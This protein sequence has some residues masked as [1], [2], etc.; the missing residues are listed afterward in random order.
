MFFVD[1]NRND[2]VCRL[3]KAE[4]A[5]LYFHCVGCEELLELDL[6]ICPACFDDKRYFAEIRMH[7]KNEKPRSDRNHTG[8]KDKLNRGKGCSCRQGTCTKCKLCPQC[9]CKCHHKF[10][11]HRRFFEK[12]RLERILVKC[13]NG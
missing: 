11:L 13:E 10:K 2:Y 6:N 8:Q 9:S 1:C 7:D 3:C 5:N 12:E 4:L